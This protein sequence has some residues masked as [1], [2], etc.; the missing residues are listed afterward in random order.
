M[1]YHAATRFMRPAGT[2]LRLVSLNRLMCIHEAKID[3]HRLEHQSGVL[4]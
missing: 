1:L 2:S 3:A 4:Q